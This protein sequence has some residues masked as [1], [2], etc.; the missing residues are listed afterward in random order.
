M[1]PN[2]LLISSVSLIEAFFSDRIHPAKDS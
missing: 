2:V 1:F